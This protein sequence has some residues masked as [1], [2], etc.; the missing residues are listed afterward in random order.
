VAT[1]QHQMRG[2]RRVYLV[3]GSP[4]LPCGRRAKSSFEESGR[5]I[6]RKRRVSSAIERERTRL[7]DGHRAPPSCGNTRA[8]G[9]NPVCAQTGCLGES[10]SRHDW[11]D[12]ELCMLFSNLRGILFS[13]LIFRL[14][15]SWGRKVWH[16]LTIDTVGVRLWKRES[17]TVRWPAKV[18]SAPDTVHAIPKGNQRR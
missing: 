14:Q 2:E 8:P 15:P 5:S 7:L 12:L 4:R 1:G 11:G 16:N 10:E 18:H 13:D 6:R 3:L 9:Q 17:E